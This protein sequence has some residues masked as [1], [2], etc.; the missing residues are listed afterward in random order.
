MLRVVISRMQCSSESR[1]PTVTG[2]PVITA[3]SGV[4][5]ASSPGS[6]TFNAQ[7]R[8][9]TMPLSAPPSMTITERTR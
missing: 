5:R 7:S 6:S 1:K 9:E 4:L 2:S 3:A 8:S